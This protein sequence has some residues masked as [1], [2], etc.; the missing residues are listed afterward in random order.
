MDPERRGLRLFPCGLHAGNLLVLQDGRVGFIDFGIVGRIPSSIW[1]AIQGVALG[2]GEGDYVAVADSLVKMGATDADVDVGAFARDLESV[3][4][5]L[6]DIEP[7]VTAGVGPSGEAMAAV[8]VD[9]QQ[10]TR[11]ALDLVGI[12]ERNG[13][14][15]PREFESFS[16]RFYISTGTHDCWRRMCRSSTTAGLTSAQWRPTPGQTPLTSDLP[17]VEVS[18]EIPRSQQIRQLPIPSGWQAI[19]AGEGGART[20]GVRLLV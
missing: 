7:V 2:V 4:K 15:L 6:D 18:P 12:A 3:V 5:S 1:G 16:S 14:K 9:E 11:L 13:V 8:G 17:V 19:S 20:C 10:V